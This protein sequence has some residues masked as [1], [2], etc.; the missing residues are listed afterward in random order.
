M[1]E[2]IQ[3]CYFVLQ[4]ISQN[5]TIICYYLWPSILILAKKWQLRFIE[6]V[7]KL[8]KIL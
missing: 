4:M 3:Y 7:K 5:L 8:T 2:S 6:I 1:G